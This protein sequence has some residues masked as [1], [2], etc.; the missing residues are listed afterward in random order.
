[1]NFAYKMA[2]GKYTTSKNV[3]IYVIRCFENTFLCFDAT[4]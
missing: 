1:M 4:Q 3:Y 2:L